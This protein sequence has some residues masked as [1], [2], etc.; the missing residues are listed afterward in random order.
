MDPPIK[1]L[2]KNEVIN[3]ILKNLNRKKAP[4]YDLITGRILKEL[5][6]K[7][8]IYL[9]QLYNAVLRTSFYPPQWK[10][11][12]IIM[13]LK[14]GKK[15]DNVTSYR[16]ISLITV[17]S[18]VFEKLLL[19]KMQPTIDE[20]KLI[21]DHQ[22]GFRQRHNTIQQVHRL[23]KKSAKALRQETTGQLPS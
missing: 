3:T 8:Y 9:T 12:E 17:I 23:V 22:F 15:P 16:P 6:E 20:L 7:G 2:K 1:N 4:G 13:I 14:P 21:P 19:L 18:K 10:V 5:P 11:A